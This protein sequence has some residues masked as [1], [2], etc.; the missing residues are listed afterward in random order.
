M[1][2]A[3]VLAV[4]KAKETDQDGL[5]IIGDDEAARVIIAWS[6]TDQHWTQ[7]KRV[8][9]AI[10]PDKTFELWRWVVEGWRIDHYD[11]ARLSGVQPAVALDKLNLLV[12][13][14][15]IYPDGTI[16]LG[17]RSA[18]RVYTA[19]KL[20][21]KLGAKNKQPKPRDDVN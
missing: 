19:N 4:F 7:P 16:A 12:G 17:G 1:I 10:V 20:G 8:A 11:V 13:N 3:D 6:H 5:V 2:L 9:P 14:R 18:L 15:L 21:V